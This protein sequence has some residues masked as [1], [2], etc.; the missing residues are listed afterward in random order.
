MGRGVEVKT[1][2]KFKDKVKV[3]TKEF[4]KLDII[5]MS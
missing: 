2:D 5:F 4:M 3:M 1:I